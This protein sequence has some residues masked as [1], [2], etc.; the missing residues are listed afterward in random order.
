MY[1]GIKK[2]SA[3]IILRC[4]L[5]FVVLWKWLS[6]IKWVQNWSLSR[7]S[8]R[9]RKTSHFGWS[10]IVT[11]LKAATKPKVIILAKEDALVLAL[12]CIDVK[13]DYCYL[14][15][16]AHGLLECNSASYFVLCLFPYSSWSTTLLHCTGRMDGLSDQWVHIQA[17]GPASWTMEAWAT[18]FHDYL[19]TI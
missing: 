19:R 1:N 12:F 2:G 17:L 5:F 4:C 6:K 3:S 10:Y 8:S 11:K 18:M 16:R 14:W 13:R 9:R 7:Y 15:F